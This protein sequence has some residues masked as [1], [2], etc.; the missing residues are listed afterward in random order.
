NLAYVI[1]TSGSTGKPKGVMVEHRSV[2]NYTHAFNARCDLADIRSFGM[3]QPLS[4]DSSVSVLFSALFNG[5]CLH[6]ISDRRASDAAALADYFSSHRID[7]LKI[8]P[9][10]LAALQFSSHAD[11][12]IPRALL[13]IG[14]EASRRDWAES[15][16]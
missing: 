7:C 5:G 2:V 1:Y 4:V 11:A 16:M 3:L 12:I 14:G 8:A 10:H 9:S 15:L 6:L 13:V